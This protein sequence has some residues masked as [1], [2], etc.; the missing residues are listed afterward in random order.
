MGL[1]QFYAIFQ[2]NWG[3][4]HEIAHGYQGM[5]GNGTLGLG[6]TSNNF[7]ALYIQRNKNIYT[8]P[9]LLNGMV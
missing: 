6:E 3:G 9:N 7:F 4:L 8:S 5:L 1:R 2:M